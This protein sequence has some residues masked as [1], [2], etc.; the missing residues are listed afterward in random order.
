D[1]NHRSSFNERWKGI[2][3][4][5]SD[6]VAE[7]RAKG[8]CFKCGG[9]FHPTLHKC[10]EKSLRLL[11]LGEGEG[12]NDE[13]EIVALEVG[14]EE[15]E[16]DLEAECKIMGVLGSMGEYRTMKIGGKLESIDVVVLIDSGA[17]HNFISSHIT[18]ALGLQ[19]S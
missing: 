4:I 13:G 7:R 2:R 9:K 18:D 12:V 6:E 15:E 19:I 11:I 8:L 17:S 16:E 3:S 10:P 5:Q 1:S 14:E